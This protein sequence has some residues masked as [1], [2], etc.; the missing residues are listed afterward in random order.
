MFQILDVFDKYKSSMEN[1]GKALG[2]YSNNPLLDKLFFFELA[3]F[4]FVTGNNDM[5]L[6]NFSMIESPFGWI[7]SPSYDLLNVSIANPQDQEE[8]ALSLGGKKKKFTRNIFIEFGS[9]LELTEKQI[10]GVF[11]RFRKN[12]PIALE[13][14]NQSFMSDGM[15]E[16]YKKV[17][18]NRYGRLLMS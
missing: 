9:G 4:S 13:W 18:E 2:T 3:V 6:K 14:I 17:L 8:L 15:K 11:K 1:I 5:H 12:L 16:E 7:L 10:S